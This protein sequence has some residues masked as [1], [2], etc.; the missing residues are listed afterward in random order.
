MGNRLRILY[1]R[2]CFKQNSRFAAL[3][4]RFSQAQAIVEG[5]TK[6]TQPNDTSP[7]SKTGADVQIVVAEVPA[8]TGSGG[9]RTDTDTA[10]VGLSQRLGVKHV[11]VS[12]VSENDQNKDQRKIESPSIDVWLDATIR[13]TPAARA[14]LSRFEHDVVGG[15]RSSRSFG[16]ARLVAAARDWGS[17]AFPVR[18]ERIVPGEDPESES[19]RVTNLY[20]RLEQLAHF[21][22]ELLAIP[23]GLRRAPHPLE[24]MVKYMEEKA[25][26]IE[27]AAGVQEAGRQ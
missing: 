22:F 18:T 20:T 11:R 21:P 3:S 1:S 10:P 4:R 15:R 8:T 12:Y 19:I 25:Q 17:G 26:E 9:Q 7:E 6:T 27:K 24:A 16:A 14:A 5:R 2:P 13:L 23:E